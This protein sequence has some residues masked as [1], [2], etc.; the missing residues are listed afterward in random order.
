M[1]LTNIWGSRKFV[2]VYS[3]SQ[4]LDTEE[5]IEESCGADRRDRK[6]RIMH[7]SVQIVS[8][9]LEYCCTADLVQE[10]GTVWNQNLFPW[11]RP[12]V[13]I[14]PREW[15]WK[16]FNIVCPWENHVFDV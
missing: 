8:K 9:N 14:S 2:Y 10:R 12:I 13:L 11:L 7:R 4:M 3:T 1:K 5:S 16:R 6:V 15:S